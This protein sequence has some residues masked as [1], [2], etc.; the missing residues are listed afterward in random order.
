MTRRDYELLAKAFNKTLPEL[1]GDETLERHNARYAQWELDIVAVC[2][3]LEAENDAFDRSLFQYNATAQ[4]S[5]PKMMPGQTPYTT[6]EY[7]N[8]SAMIAEAA[9]TDPGEAHE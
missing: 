2:D 6:T 4:K 5:E 3:A 8:L 9:A 7:E 1:Q